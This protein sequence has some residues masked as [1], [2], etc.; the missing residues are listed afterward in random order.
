MPNSQDNILFVTEF[1][2]VGTDRGDLH[3]FYTQPILNGK[4]V[5]QYAA[6]VAATWTTCNHPKRVPE[7][8]IAHIDFAAGSTSTLVVMAG[9]KEVLLVNTY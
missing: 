5:D 7:H 6:N 8:R 3:V 4:E 2:A 9:K 1:V